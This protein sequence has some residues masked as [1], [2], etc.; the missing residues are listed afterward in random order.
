MLIVINFYSC[1]ENSD[2]VIDPSIS[3][4]LISGQFQSADTIYTNSG[5]PSI[6][7]YTSVF[8]ESNGGEPIVN[9]SMN[10]NDPDGNDL[11]V[12]NLIDNGVLPDTV[13]GDG[14]YSAVVL[15]DNISC[16]LVGTYPLEYLAVNQS[17]LN[18]NLIT[19][20]I[21][22]ANSA[23]LPPVIQSTSLPD[24]VI[25]PFAGDSTLLTIS[26]NVSDSD[27]L[28]DLKEV[29]FVTVRPNGVILPAIPM[30]N[31]G[32]GQFL[33]SNYVSFSS[34]PTSYGYFKYT[35]TARDRSNVLSSPVTDSIKFVQPVK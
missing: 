29:T 27:G 11:A 18:S 33:F 2:A 20:S 1:E 16:L 26:V 22:T 10:I 9:V 31:N 3:S 6:V 5:S 14:I 17:G 28:C 32:N 8:A 7:F 21:Y 35:F 4:P 24:S 30:S 25:R 13:S 23:N 34:D 12:I 15:I 19:S